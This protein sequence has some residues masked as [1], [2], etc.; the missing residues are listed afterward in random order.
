MRSVNSAGHSAWVEF[1]YTYTNSPPPP[2]ITTLST[3]SSGVTRY[4]FPTYS[5]TL[6][7][8]STRFYAIDQYQFRFTPVLGGVPVI[9]FNQTISTQLSGSLTIAG[10]PFVGEVSSSMASRIAYIA[11]GWHYCIV[12]SHRFH[13]HE[14]T[15]AHCV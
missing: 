11:S 12:A 9:T 15:S 1:D 3:S 6:T 7:A 10:L 2:T 5:L 14:L 13:R 4:V 8:T